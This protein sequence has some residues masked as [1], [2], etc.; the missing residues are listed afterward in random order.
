MECFV[1][2]DYRIDNIIYHR[3][4]NRVLAVLDWELASIGHPV[5]DLAYAS[6]PYIFPVGK[7]LPGLYGLN[8]RRLGIPSLADFVSSYVRMARHPGPIQHFDYYVALSLLRVASILQVCPQTFISFLSISLHVPHFTSIYVHMKPTS[9]LLYMFI[10]NRFLSL[11]YI[12][13]L[14][15]SHQPPSSPSVITRCNAY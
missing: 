11:I 15:L 8:L 1:H 14:T 7:G 2:G 4:G 6:L 9:F 10:C 5:A 3:T 13:I 12:Y